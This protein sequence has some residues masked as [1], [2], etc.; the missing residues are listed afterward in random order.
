MNLKK[1]RLSKEFVG[2]VHKRAWLALCLIV[3]F[4]FMG[5]AD[6]YAQSSA[7]ASRMNISDSCSNNNIYGLTSTKI[8]PALQGIFLLINELVNGTMKNL[9]EAI[10]N[11]GGYASTIGAAAQLVILFYGIS[12][13]LGFVPLT[14]AQGL[15]RIIKIALVFTLVSPVGWEMFEATFVTFFR[16]GGTYLTAKLAE[17]A[18]TSGTW[19]NYST[20]GATFSWGPN[21]FG[22]VFTQG[23]AG[24]IAVFDNLFRVAFSPRMFILIY[25]SFM[26]GPYGI[27]MALA[28]AWAVI[29]LL[30]M[31]VKALEV[32]GMSIV[33]KAVLL[34]L[35]PIFLVFLLFDRTKSIFMGWLNQLVSF[36]LQP[37]FL[38]A[39]ISFFVTILEVAIWDMVPDRAHNPVNYVEAC[40]M[41]KPGSSTGSTYDPSFWQFLIQGKPYEGTYSAT[42]PTGFI[43]TASSALGLMPT[44]PIPLIPTLIVLILAYVG[45]GMTSAATGLASSVAS[46][47]VNLANNTYNAIDT[48]AQELMGIK[49]HDKTKWRA[50]KK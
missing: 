3:V 23:I 41:K 32:Y 38:F 45:K 11:S 16:D 2:F 42:G 36:T 22:V 31:C 18:A 5:A 37:V 26:A 4:L 15:N 8:I 33:M 12:F 39:F 19:L 50:G 7:I 17:V 35:G 40:Y 30:S 46:A 21:G 29:Q 13:L 10:V 49:N 34:G 25:A 6:G 27:A 47:G 20:G 28:M 43:G 9:F 14:L 44:F 24:P 48:T 1:E